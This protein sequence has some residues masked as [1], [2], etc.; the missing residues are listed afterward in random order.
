[1]S[2]KQDI[3]ILSFEAALERVHDYGDSFNVL[4]GNGFSRAYNDNIFSYRSLFESADFSKL[5]NESQ[6]AFDVLQTTDF[7]KVLRSLDSSSK[8]LKL[9]APKEKKLIQNILKDLEDIRDLLAKT[10]AKRHPPRS[11]AIEHNCYLCCRKFLHHFDKIYT[12]NYDLLL[13]WALMQED[14]ECAIPCDDGFRTPDS[15]PSEFVTWEAENV[16]NQN[17]YYLHGAL[18]IYDAGHEIRKYTWCNTGESLINQ[19]KDALNDGMYP[20]VVTE[21]SYEQ[22]LEKIHK[23]DFLGKAYRSFAITKKPLFIYGHS[24][25]ES[26][27]HIIKLIEKGKINCLMIGLYGKPDEPNNRKIRQVANLMQSRRGSP[28]LDVYYYDAKS[29]NLWREI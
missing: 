12:L 5:S 25:S 7:E 6:K 20:L 11:T 4:L 28:R 3:E 1:M 10:I 14:E 24:M 26:D 13:Y 23:S 21:G 22:K 2:K 15:G 16:L 8:L 17:I 27:K 18:H 19:I 9:Y 29:V